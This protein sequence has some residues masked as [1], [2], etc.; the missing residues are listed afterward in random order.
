M[1]QEGSACINSLRTAC[2]SAGVALTW[3][4]VEGIDD[5]ALMVAVTEPFGRI[6]LGHA[7]ISE[8]YVKS[9]R[10]PSKV[11]L[12]WTGTPCKDPANACM[13]ERPTLIT[14]MHSGLCNLDR[15]CYE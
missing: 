10:I 5:V 12:R 1:L 13:S 9:Q 6:Q 8:R 3:L 15:S 4:Q 2:R 14:L 7:G 11:I